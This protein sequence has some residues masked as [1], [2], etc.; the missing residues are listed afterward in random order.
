MFT[1]RCQTFFFSP[2]SADEHERDWPQSKVVFFGLATNQYAEC[3]KQHQAPSFVWFDDTNIVYYYYP[4]NYA[5]QCLLFCYVRWLYMVINI[6]VKY[7]GGLF[8]DIILLTQVK[9]T[10]IGELV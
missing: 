6:S 2:C 4:P 7:D 3:G 9:V 8:P 5:L 10:T 1:V